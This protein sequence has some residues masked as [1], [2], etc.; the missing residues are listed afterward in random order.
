MGFR[1]VDVTMTPDTAI[2]ASADVIADTQVGTNVC[3]NKNI[4]C[5]L[6]SIQVIDPDDQGAAFDIY[7]FSSNVSLGTENSGASITDANSL[8]ILGKVAIATGDYTDFGGTRSAAIKNIDMILKP[9]TDTTDVYIGIVNGSGTPT[10]AGGAITLR[11]GL[12]D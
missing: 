1:L 10:Y 11:L 8:F 9:V 6:K 2:L 12:E 5:N 7:F 3:R 4:A